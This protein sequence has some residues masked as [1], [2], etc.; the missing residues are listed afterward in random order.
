M[1]Q[2]SLLSIRELLAADETDASKSPI[3]VKHTEILNQTLSIR[4][5]IINHMLKDGVPDNTLKLE[6][7]GT[8]LNAVDDSVFKRTK[9]AMLQRQTELDGGKLDMIAEAIKKSYDTKATLPF[10]SVSERRVPDG[11]LN[12]TAVPG[13]IEIHPEKLDP[14][15]FIRGYEDSSR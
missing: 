1:L 3:P 7:L 8:L 4:G 15:K 12:I 14:S 13:E 11:L 9:L 6:V 2:E 5:D 10:A